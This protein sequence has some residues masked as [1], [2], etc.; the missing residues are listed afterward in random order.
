MDEI[1]AAAMW[2]ESNVTTNAQG[3]IARHVSDCFGKRL[4]V[5]E[6]CI[7]ELGQNHVPPKSESIILDDKKNTLLDQ[8]FRQIINKIIVE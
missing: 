7:T 2:Q 4:I 8:T 6:T 3:I 5:P 1:S